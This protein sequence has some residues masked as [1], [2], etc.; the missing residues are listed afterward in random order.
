M[1]P[2]DMEDELA[3]DDLKRGLLGGYSRY[4]DDS[5]IEN[6]PLTT[7]DSNGPLLRRPPRYK[8]LPKL[9]PIRFSGQR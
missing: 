5:Y 1:T 6:H 3:M 9:K 4:V 8:P 2:E 7:N